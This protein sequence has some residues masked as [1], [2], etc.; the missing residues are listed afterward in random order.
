MGI[1]MDG[2]QLAATGARVSWAPPGTDLCG[3]RQIRLWMGWIPKQL[4]VI[5]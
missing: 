3:S 4:A 5:Y 2:E 1:V